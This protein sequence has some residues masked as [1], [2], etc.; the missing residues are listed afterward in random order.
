MS[1]LSSSQS[2]RA[3]MARASELCAV[4]CFFFGITLATILEA[5][6]Q[7]RIQSFLLLGLLPAVGFYAGGRALF[8]LAM[9]GRERRR[10]YILRFVEHAYRFAS[11]TLAKS[12]MLGQK[13]YDVAL[14]CYPHVRRSVVEFSCLV[15]RSAAQLILKIQSQAGLDRHRSCDALQAQARADLRSTTYLRQ[16]Q[17]GERLVQEPWA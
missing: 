7:Q 2:N 14:L 10:E 5:S 6:L 1:C 8:H 17:S 16:W 12:A 13:T 9:I 4:V 11:T 15:I 3:L